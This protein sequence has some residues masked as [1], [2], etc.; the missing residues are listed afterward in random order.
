MFPFTTSEVN[1]TVAMV[2]LVRVTLTSANGAESPDK[3]V[4]PVSRVEVKVSADALGAP[5][6]R[7]HKTATEKTTVVPTP[8]SPVIRC[9]SRKGHKPMQL[10]GA[11]RLL[12]TRV[13]ILA[14]LT[15]ILNEITSTRSERATVLALP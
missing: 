4:L 10:A 15:C 1:V 11:R 13:A 14:T 3:A 9:T 5:S 12:S 6:V 7:R 2:E 8:R